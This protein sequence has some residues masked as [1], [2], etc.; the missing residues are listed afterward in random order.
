MNVGQLIDSY[1]WHD[2]SMIEITWGGVEAL[3][4]ISKLE[5]LCE[6]LFQCNVVVFKIQRIKIQRTKCN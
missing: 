1:D 4:A 6:H 5:I 3:K 2:I